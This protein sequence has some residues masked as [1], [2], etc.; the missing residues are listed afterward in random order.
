MAS[1]GLA[2]AVSL[3]VVYPLDYAR[4][5]LASDVGSGKKTFAGLGDCLVKTMKGPKG[6]FSLYNGFG[7]SVAGIIPYRGV[8]FGARGRSC[9]LAGA[10]CCKTHAQDARARAGLIASRRRERAHTCAFGRIPIRTLPD[11]HSRSCVH[12]H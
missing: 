4:T 6:F 2:G 3:C 10:Q 12:A 1:G 9:T 7:I 8:Q 5:R 11:A